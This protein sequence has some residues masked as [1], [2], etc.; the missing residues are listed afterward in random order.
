MKRK[1]F[2]KWRG[3]LLT[4]LWMVSVGIFAQNIT[5]TGTVVDESGMT[6]VG[7]TVIVSGN[8]TKGSVTDVDGKYSLSNV[9][10]DAVLEF[11]YIGMK[12]QSVKV[13]G[14]TVVNVTMLPDVELLEEV[15]VVGYGS[16]KKV[17]L[18]GSVA[19]VDVAKITESRIKNYLKMNM[20]ANH[21]NG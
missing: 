5:V 21:L 1:S 9:P 15:V 7:A 12:S 4:Y 10:S 18:T 14:R 3:L 17:N 16:Q 20:I 6:V 13:N 11:S 19:S 2:C 8:L